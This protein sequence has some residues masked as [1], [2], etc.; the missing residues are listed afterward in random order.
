MH[1]PSLE[2]I[3]KA[4]H[5]AGIPPRLSEEQ[6]HLLIK[7]WQSVANGEAIAP[8]RLKE[9]A[10]DDNVSA[11]EVAALLDQA[12]EYDSHGNIV[13]LFGLSQKEHPHRFR[14]RGYSM[15]TATF[16][17]HARLSTWCAWDSLF[18]PVL[19]NQTAEVESACPQ[20]KDPIRLTI[21][22]DEVKK[23]KP[24]EAV[25]SIVLPE[26]A[27]TETRSPGVLWKTFCHHVFFFSSMAAASEWFKGKGLDYRILSISDGYQLT[28]LVFA[29]I[30]KHIRKPDG[31]T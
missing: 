26:P 24:E 4:L 29:D 31:I 8:A 16:H 20:T 3:V 25:L 18:L 9:I 30:L 22:P 13:G 6:S 15:S 2:E 27:E 28:R 14:L 7:I 19:L 5:D 10:S 23:Y 17:V 1:K 12:A 11:H 21:S